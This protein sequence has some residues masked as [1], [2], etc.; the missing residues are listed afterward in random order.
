MFRAQVESLQEQLEAQ[1]RKDAELQA[2]REWEERRKREEEAKT[3][4]V[5]SFLKSR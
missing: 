3:K 1:R 5:C 2:A 4:Q